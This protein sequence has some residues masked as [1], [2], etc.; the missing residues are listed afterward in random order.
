MFRRAIAPGTEIR[1]LEPCDAEV[2]FAIADRDRAYLDE[3]LPWVPATHSADDVRRFIEDVVAVQWTNDRGPQCGIW[4][5]GALAGSIGCHAIDWT[6]RACSLGYWIESRRQGQ[7]I[8]TRSVAALLEYLFDIKRLHRVVIQ[9]GVG[10]QRS[11]AIPE[12]LGFIKEGVLRDA[13]LI[14]GR[15]VDLAVWSMLEEEWCSGQ[16]KVEVPPG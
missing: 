13:Q 4:V 6:N 9:C 5:E 16:K 1:L 10:N 8:V 7:G 11:C 2:L 14:G 3:W 12:R 15:W